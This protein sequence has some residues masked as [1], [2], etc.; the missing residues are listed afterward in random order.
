MMSHDKGVAM[1]VSKFLDPKNDYAFKT[2]FGTEKN[3]AI[4]VHFLNDMLSFKEGEKI[5][6]VTFLKTHQDPEIASKKQSIVDVL[7]TDEKGT[8]YIVEMQVA[9]SAAFA[10][11]A[12]Y[13]AAK[14]YVSQMNNGDA[15]QNLKQIIFLAITDFIM[16][17]DR[18]SYKSDHVI[19]DKDTYKHDL[20]DFFF[21]FLELP[22]F[23]KTIDQLETIIEKWA[24]FFK[25]ASYTTEDEL[26]KII[27]TDSVIGKAYQALNQFSWSEEELRT[28]EQEKKSQLDAKDLLLSAEMKGKAEGIAQ[29]KVEGIAQGKVEGIAQGKV[30]EKIEI[31]KNLLSQGISFST[32]VTCTGLSKEEIQQLKCSPSVGRE[33]RGE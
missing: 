16:F 18:E 22:K 11:R 21:C 1:A 17:P 7:C 25:N 13:Y 6:D 2:I 33:R 19:L 32:I 28:Y 5:Q 29:G 12:Q 15:Y 9:H 30:E 26:D 4:L 8:Q 23:K 14:A 24:Y 20:K 10:K 27:G 31:A 3:K